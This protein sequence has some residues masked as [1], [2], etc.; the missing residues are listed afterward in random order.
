MV[1]RRFY[2]IRPFSILMLTLFLLT[3]RVA[4][5]DEV[6]DAKAVAL[7]F[8]K[9]SDQEDLEGSYRMA[10]E[11]LRHS[12]P[13]SESIAGMRKWFEVKGGAASSREL[14]MQRTYT[15]TE[16]NTAFPLVKTK[17]SLY[18]FRFRSNY[19]KGIFFEDIFVSRDSDGVLRVNGHI[20]QPG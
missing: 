7:D 19:P 8:L 4:L 13:K 2:S 6:S 11:Q 16:A 14:V 9:L 1:S 3:L 5:A 10:G 15:E 18:G 20:P 17:G 12:T